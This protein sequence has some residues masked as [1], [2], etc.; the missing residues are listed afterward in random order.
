MIG[1]KKWI[2]GTAL[3]KHLNSVQNKGL[4]MRKNFFENM[5]YNRQREL[6]G[7][8]ELLNSSGQES[9]AYLMKTMF[10]L[11]QEGYEIAYDFYPYNYGPFSQTIYWDLDYLKKQELI[12]NEERKITKKGKEESKLTEKIKEQIIKITSEFEDY[13]SL[14]DFVY[15]KFPEYTEKSV[16]LDHKK[17]KQKGKYTIGYEGKS[18]D[19]FMNQLIQ[20]KITKLIDVRKNAFSM[21][22]GFS[23][24]TLKTTLE[25][26]GIE[27]EHIPKLGIESDKRQKLETKEDYKKLFKEYRKSL[28]KRQNELNYVGEA[29]KK[30][31]IAIMC[32][33]KDP[34]YCHRGQI[35]ENI[36]GFLHL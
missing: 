15:E 34:E 11:K 20:N 21:K 6:L 32:F 33:E 24:S 14:R 17:T 4:N 18:I 28:P 27:Y 26:A 35:S 25:N 7:V 9:K 30:E 13:E 19:L 16:L 10:L 5:L 8:I 1:N 29:G 36:G 22:R 23:K 2:T 3:V 31:R 12:D